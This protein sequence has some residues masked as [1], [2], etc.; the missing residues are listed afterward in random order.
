MT[1]VQAYQITKRGPKHFRYEDQHGRPV[2]KTVHKPER[3]KTVGGVMH[4]EEGEYFAPIPG[5]T[6][7]GYGIGDG[8]RDQIK[9][10]PDQAAFLKHMGL[11]PVVSGKTEAPKPPEGGTVTDPTSVDL[12]RVEVPKDWHTMSAKDRK[13]LAARIM[14]D[15]DAAESM[16]AKEADEI[17][18][19]YLQE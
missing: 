3:R 14:G 12:A 6:L 15:P 18:Q 11:V 2:T 5:V 13:E 17:I 10:T 4:V 9:C 16:R 19:E 8:L 1:N 7:V